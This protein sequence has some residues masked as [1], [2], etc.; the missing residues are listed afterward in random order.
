V[1]IRL[2]LKRT[3]GRTSTVRAIVRIDG[4]KSTVST[5]VKVQVR[6]WDK[7]RERCKTDHAA[8]KRL[9]AAIEEIKS[10]AGRF[11]KAPERVGL[12]KHKQDILQ[13]I[14]E[15]REKK[16]QESTSP[17]TWRAYS[18]LS[19]NIRQFTTE[20][21]TP[22]PRSS[23]ITGT[24]IE[25]LITWMRGKNYSTSHVS[26][27]VRTLR[28]ALKNIAP[29]QE[30]KATKPP[31]AQPKDAVYLTPE[32]ITRIEAVPLRESL[33]K[34]RDLFLI[35]LYCGQR[36]SDWYKITPNRTQQTGAVQTITITQQ[37]TKSRAVI[38]ITAKIKAVWDR[39]PTGLPI[40]SNQ[41]FNQHIKEVCQIAGINEQIQIT[42]YRMQGE[43][44]AVFEKWQLVSSHTARRSFATNAAIAGIPLQEIMKFTGHK[45]VSTLLI[46][47]RNTGIETAIAYAGHEFFQ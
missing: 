26:K 18:T 31:T 27:M 39:Y 17:H 42:E 29:G 14:Q 8:N 32:E 43:T 21:Q 3:T 33:S 41:K 13:A 15:H 10:H 2:N 34:A 20:T 38:I 23:D 5:G 1:T 37:K 4:K 40:I 25:N 9:D 35:G 28:A 6:D 44:V 46:Y 16:V 12:P 47:L 36:F 30:L 22:L 45:T 11:G 24:Y 19:G 7:K